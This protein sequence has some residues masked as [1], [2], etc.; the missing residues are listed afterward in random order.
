MPHGKKIFPLTHLNLSI[1][2]QRLVKDLHM[3]KNDLKPCSI[4]ALP[5]NALILYHLKIQE[6]QT[7]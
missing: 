1:V 3:R 4:N 2:S 5:N 7:I 6:N